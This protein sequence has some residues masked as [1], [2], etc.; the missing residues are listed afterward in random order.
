MEIS[1]S[2]TKSELQLQPTPQLWQHQI[3]NSL[4][5]AKY[6]IR[7]LTRLRQVLNLPRHNGNYFFFF[8]LTSMT[9][10]VLC[11]VLESQG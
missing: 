4:K 11:W 3:P 10:W 2:G 1:G 5:E 6:G 7:I 9:Y 8:F